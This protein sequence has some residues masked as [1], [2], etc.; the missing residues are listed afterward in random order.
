MDFRRL[1]DQVD[2]S[3]VISKAISLDL[4]PYLI[5]W[6]ADF[7]A[8]RRQAV[9]YEGFSF[10]ELTCG[11]SQ[12]TKICP[13]CFWLLI[14]NAL[15]NNSH[16]RKYME[17]CTMD[18]PIKNRDSDYFAVQATLEQLQAWAEENKMTINHGKSVVM[19]HPHLRQL[20]PY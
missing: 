18:V 14:Y 1:F 19:R 9:R 11:V 10:Q 8:K 13:L 6:L 17:Y 5:A 2:H 12:G 16:R 20:L 15:T 4:P 7:H 3:I